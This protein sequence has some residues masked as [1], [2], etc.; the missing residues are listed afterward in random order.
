MGASASGGRPHF[1]SYRRH[2]GKVLNPKNLGCAMLKNI[3]ISVDLNPKG[4]YTELNGLELRGFK[5]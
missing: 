5:V 1:Y 3:D 4:L 2:K